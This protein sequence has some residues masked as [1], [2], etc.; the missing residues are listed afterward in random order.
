MNNHE[1]ACYEAMLKVMEEIWLL[2]GGEP[3]ELSD[4]LSAAQ[5][6]EDGTSKDPAIYARFLEIIG[7]A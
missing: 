3:N 2:R 1:R 6:Y 7:G 5:L 4:F